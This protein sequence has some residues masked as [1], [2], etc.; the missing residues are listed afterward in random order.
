MNI[1]KIFEQD[2]IKSVPKYVGVIRMPD[3]AQAF[4]HSPNLRFSRKNP[5]DFIFWN[6]SLKFFFFSTKLPM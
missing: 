5:Y 3:A 2:I 6:F 1:G 4:F